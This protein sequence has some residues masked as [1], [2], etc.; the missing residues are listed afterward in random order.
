MSRWNREE[1]LA[2]AGVLV[3]LLCG[4]LTISTPEVRR[5]IGLH[6]LGMDP[7]DKIYSDEI[8]YP[9]PVGDDPEPEMPNLLRD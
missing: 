9:L 3:T 8:R 2:L 4:V 7:G 5:A 6:A 1:K